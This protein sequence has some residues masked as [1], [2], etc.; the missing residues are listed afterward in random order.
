MLPDDVLLEIFEFYVHKDSEEDF[1]FL[2]KEVEVWQTL[3][4]VCPRWRS[5]VFGSPRRLNLRLVC[6]AGTPARDMLDVWP[7]LPLLIHDGPSYAEVVD[8]ILAALEHRDRV[9]KIHLFESDDSDLEN[10]LA[11]M[12]EPYPEL[13]EL[14]LHSFGGKVSV[15]PDSFL[16]GSATT[17]PIPLFGLDSNSGFTETTFVCHS[18]RHSSP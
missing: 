5:V 17:S 8:E 11:A 3:A 9:V 13:T 16:G 12:Q 7:S 10:V 14:M 18:P 15:I 2:K 6:T 1:V 4:H